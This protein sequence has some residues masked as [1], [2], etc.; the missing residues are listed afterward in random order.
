MH[1]EANEVFESYFS[2]IRGDL[3]KEQLKLILR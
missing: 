3:F 1:K 2:S